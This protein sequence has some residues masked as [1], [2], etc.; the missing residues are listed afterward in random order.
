ML[1]LS[2]CSTITLRPCRF[3]RET[4]DRFGIIRR[5]GTSRVVV[6]SVGLAACECFRT[7]SAIEAAKTVLAERFG[8]SKAAIDLSPLV[9]SLRNADLIASV[10]GQSI[11][12]IS[13]PSLY[14]AYRHFLRFD[15]A[16]SCSASHTEAASRC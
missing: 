11:P 1:D 3:V 2:D 16:P 10:D 7:G 15:I 6:K 13:P 9:R 12:E 5:A 8:A 4:A 14:S